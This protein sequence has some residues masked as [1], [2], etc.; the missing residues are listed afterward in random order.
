MKF[1]FISVFLIFRIKVKIFPPVPKPV[2]TDFIPH[3]SK[4]QVKGRGL[5]LQLLSIWFLFPVWL[6]R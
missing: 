4:T 5:D 3:Q 6:F 1:L 2:I